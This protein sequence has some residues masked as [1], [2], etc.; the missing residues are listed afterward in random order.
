MSFNFAV[1]K[2]IDFLCRKKK[3]NKRKISFQYQSKLNKLSRIEIPHQSKHPK[4][5]AGEGGW[6][7]N[8]PECDLVM[9]TIV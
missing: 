7:T 1:E 4:G 3:Q 2:N 5:F 9:A 6:D 8:P